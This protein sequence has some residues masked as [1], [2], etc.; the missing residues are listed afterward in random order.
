MDKVIKCLL[1]K[2]RKINYTYQTVR[3]TGHHSIDATK[4]TINCIPWPH[5]KETQ[6][7]AVPLCQRIYATHFFEI[8]SPLI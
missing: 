7:P 3:A 1:T 4:Y 6:T 2:L 5:G 8:I